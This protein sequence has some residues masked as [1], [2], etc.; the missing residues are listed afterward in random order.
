L[1][2]LLAITFLFPNN[3]CWFL[4]K[5][6]FIFYAYTPLIIFFS[7]FEDY[8]QEYN[9]KYGVYSYLSSQIDKTKYVV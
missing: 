1:L 4:N 5:I 8:V 2:K 9:E 7:R 3:F 6:T